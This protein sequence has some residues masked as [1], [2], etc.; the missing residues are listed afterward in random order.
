[1][2]TFRKHASATTQ[3]FDSRLTRRREGAR[4]VPR[5]VLTLF[6]AVAVCVSTQAQTPEAAPALT[7]DAGPAESARATTDAPA[8]PP[9]AAPAERGSGS[10]QVP[11]KLYVAG[12]PEDPYILA[13]IGDFPEALGEPGEEFLKRE[14]IEQ[15]MR[16]VLGLRGRGEATALKI[17]LLP[18]ERGK[19]REQECSFTFGDVGGRISVRLVERS[20][21]V[22][23]SF[24][25]KETQDAA[26][27]LS[28]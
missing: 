21:F 17:A 18:Q 2:N 6:A 15:F 27:T 26:P 25:Q 5:I 14:F 11:V 28:A 23:V 4:A 20:V 8:I 22:L 10:P 24:D 12:T 1:M 9:A 7:R 19:E 16:D 3:R 13:R